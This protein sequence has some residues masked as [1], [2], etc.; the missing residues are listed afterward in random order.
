MCGICGFYQYE[1]S[2]GQAT[3]TIYTMCQ[4]MEHRGPDDVGVYQDQSLV[5]G[6]RRLSI[7]DLNTGHQ[8]ISNESATIWVVV[9][10]EI[11]NFK[12]LRDTLKKKGHV[13]KTGSD[14]E[15]L[16][17]LYEEY[18]I[19]CLDKINGMFA[20]AIWDKKE[21]RLFLARDRIGIKPLHYAYFNHTFIFGSE[22][23]S[24][25]QYPGFQKN[26]NPKGVSLY[27]TYEY[28]PSPETIFQSIKKLPPG[29][30]LLI[31][32]K[33]GPQIR[34]YW[35]LEYRSK[36]YFK[37]EKEYQELVLEKLKESVHKRLISDVPLGT[38]LSGGIDSSLIVAI[39]KGFNESRVDSFNIGFYEKS[40]DESKYA[41]IVA[42][43]LAI[44]HQSQM[45]DTG[46]LLKGLPEITRI[47][48][49]PFGDA[50]ILPTYLLCKFCRQ[51]VTVALSGDGGD[52]LFAG[53]YTYQAHRLA[54][55]YHLLPYLIR[56]GIIENM[57]PKLP[58]S[59]KNFSFDFRAK[60]FISGIDCPP[61]IRNYIWL[62]SFSPEEKVTLLQA[63]FFKTVKDFDEFSII[64]NL[65]R[66]APVED[67][68]DSI[69]YLDMK[70]YLQEDLLVKVDRASM[71]NSLEVRVPFLDHEFV[72]VA[73]RLPSNYKLR[74]M[75]TKYLL[76]KTALS[77][78]P[79]RIVHRPKK[80][81][82]IPVAEW[83]KKELKPLFVEIFDRDKICSQGIFN[84]N[85]INRL[86]QDHWKGSVD[87]RKKL[88]TLFMFQ[89]WYEN[90]FKNV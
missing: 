81:F 13:F 28:I 12:E 53:Y 41:D 4:V 48:D 1:L 39:M 59:T 43:L 75:Q 73:T 77:Y 52:E 20:F 58:V 89:R 33:G 60:K 50:S 15:V 36:L 61:G 56:K 10:G 74:G 88:W 5:M 57:V 86:L 3:Q 76:K 84:Y 79:S 19:E 31:D 65:L 24:I 51:H 44:N 38:F 16:I 11:Y 68:L 8:P 82:G 87:N 26:I 66:S 72:N 63:D 67:W 30:F 35:D 14:S 32:G 47:L 27:L 69:L 6:M 25:L 49:E 80:G 40:F 22:I 45:F 29:H 62:G 54:K 71:A 7:I 18:G 46:A 42:K 21:K 2:E 78:L 85:E 70:L 55:L 90:I 34:Q 64:H 9:N 37:D 83:V 23:K 17:H